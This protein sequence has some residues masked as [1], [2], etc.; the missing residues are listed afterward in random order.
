MNNSTLE[1]NNNHPVHVHMIQ[2]HKIL[3]N[4]KQATKITIQKYS[5]QG[6]Q[7]SLIKTKID[8]YHQDLGNIFY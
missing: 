8:N 7:S 4:K 1:C 3:Y 2:V 5:Y 6:H